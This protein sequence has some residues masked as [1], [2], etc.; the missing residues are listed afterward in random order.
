MALFIVRK[1][2]N[3]Q[4]N[5]RQEGNQVRDSRCFKIEEEDKSS[6]LV[7]EQM[8]RTGEISR[9][10]NKLKVHWASVPC[11]EVE[12]ALSEALYV[13]CVN[14]KKKKEID[15]PL[16]FIWRISG[17]KISDSYK[18]MK[19][20][21]SVS[22]EKLLLLASRSDQVNEEVTAYSAGENKKNI[23]KAIE[24]A[25]KNINKSGNK[26]IQKVLLHILK[27]MEQGEGEV[28]NQDI[29][30]AVGLRAATVRVYKFRAFKNLEK[31]FREIGINY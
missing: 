13:L 12:L 4:D 2:M 17:H 29:A 22:N 5:F 14:I 23:G 1:F 16:A 25:R 3:Y 6:E 30:E 7:L 9:M 21:I 24:I 31:H 15:N 28:S 27:R 11:H 18:R 20:E 26:N 19:R 10:C 8:F